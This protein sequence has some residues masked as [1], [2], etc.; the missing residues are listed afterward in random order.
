MKFVP[1]WKR[2]QST[3]FPFCYVRL[4]WED[5]HLW[6]RM[7]F[8]SETEFGGALILAFP[9][10]RTV[11]VKCL[12]LKQPSL[13]IFVIAAWTDWDTDLCREGDHNIWSLGIPYGLSSHS[14]LHDLESYLPHFQ[15]SGKTVSNPSSR[16]HLIL[17]NSC[18]QGESILSL[19]E[20]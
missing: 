6:T 12:L 14:L 17:K 20:L 8:S 11:R 4:Q 19:Y 18:W 16:K 7:L 10:S 15:T 3:P 13:W 2:P 5:S 1:L 9:A